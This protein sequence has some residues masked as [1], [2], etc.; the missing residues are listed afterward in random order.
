MNIFMV[1]T[2]EIVSEKSDQHSINFF[3]VSR[4]FL[5]SEKNYIYG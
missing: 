1:T 5:L 3:D 4:E 2:L